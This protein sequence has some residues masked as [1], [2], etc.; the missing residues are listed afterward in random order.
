MGL[1]RQVPR[2]ETNLHGYCLLENEL[3][4]VGWREC[5]IRDFSTV[6]IGIT[7]HH[8]EATELLGRTIFVDVPS[9]SDS[10]R[11]RSEGEIKNV[12][13]LEP[14]LV[15]AGVLFKGSATAE[16]AAVALLRALNEV[17]DQ[18]ATVLRMTRRS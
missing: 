12:R 14:G 10:D 5:Q 8:G 17:N 1:R 2:Q 6:G 4:T 13:I 3:A 16:R 7:L 11:V 15:R 9:A 18:G